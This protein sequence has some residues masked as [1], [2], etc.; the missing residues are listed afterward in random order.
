MAVQNKPPRMGRPNRNCHYQIMKV[1]ILK[2]AKQIYFVALHQLEAV[3]AE[4]P[5]GRA[6]EKNLLQLHLQPPLLGQQLA[7][8]PFQIQIVQVP[9]LRS[10]LRSSLLDR[11]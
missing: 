8:R 1:L 2:L 10:P 7:F 3:K 6:L 9:V 5:P 4:E 11:E